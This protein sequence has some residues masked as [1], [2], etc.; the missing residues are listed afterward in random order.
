ML[1]PFNLKHILIKENPKRPFL[2][3]N[4]K[5]EHEHLG[6]LLL[7]NVHTRPPTQQGD[8]GTLD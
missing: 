6:A 8:D 4:L 7:A 2:G 3:P 1:L 5:Q